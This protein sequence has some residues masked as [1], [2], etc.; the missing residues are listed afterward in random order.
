MISDSVGSTMRVPATGNGND[1]DQAV[2]TEVI[3]LTQIFQAAL[4]II[5]SG[6]ISVGIAYTLQVVAQKNAHPAHAAIILSM[7][8][9]FAALG[10]WIVLNEILSPREISGCTLMLAGMI[11]SQLWGYWRYLR[12]KQI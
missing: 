9:V 11:L 5:F 7:E 6:V 2:F 3:A 10:G 8:T 4:P 1:A 12:Q